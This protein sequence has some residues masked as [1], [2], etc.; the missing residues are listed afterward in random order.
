MCQTPGSSACEICCRVVK[1][2]AEAAGNAYWHFLPHT[3]W[4]DNV[5]YMFVF[6]QRQE[7]STSLQ[8]MQPTNLKSCICQW[9]CH[10]LTLTRSSFF[11]LRLLSIRTVLLSRICLSVRLSVCLSNACIVTKQKHLAK[12][13]QL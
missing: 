4:S 7:G 2:I 1:T 3:H 10:L 8:C 11:T 9:L 12:K 6:E 5:Y 13:V